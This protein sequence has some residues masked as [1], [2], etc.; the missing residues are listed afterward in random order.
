MVESL[1]SSDAARIA[2]I[3]WQYRRQLERMEFLLE[4]QLLLATA[5][6]DQL[7]YHVADLLEE[8]ADSLSYINLQREVLL[9]DRGVS[10]DLTLLVSI[11]EEPWDEVFAD[12]QQWFVAKIAR[13]Q[14]LSARNK[15]TIEQSQTAL[16]QL[17]DLLTGRTDDA[18]D[19][20]GNRVSS[21]SGG[22][23]LFDGQV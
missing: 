15:R 1:P 5:G 22:G 23:M 18:Y 8:T 7:L 21:A 4:T 19:G 12:H 2:D 10:V 16:N 14:E 6:K 3:L 20:S 9:S 17:A 11:V 13:I